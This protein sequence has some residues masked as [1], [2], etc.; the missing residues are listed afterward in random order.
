MKSEQANPA[1]AK[2]H[3]LTIDLVVLGPREGGPT[4]SWSLDRWHLDEPMELIEYLLEQPFEHVAKSSMVE[5]LH[6]IA[7]STDPAWV[8]AAVTV[9]EQIAETLLPENRRTPPA[10]TTH[11]QNIERLYNATIA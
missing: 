8:N 2:W 4:T 1:R 9:L 6:E 3:G 10:L 11:R 7:Q 5:K